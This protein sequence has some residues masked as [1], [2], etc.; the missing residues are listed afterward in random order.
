MQ[1]GK[2]IVGI[3]LCTDGWKRRCAGGGTPLINLMVL[4]R[5]H[6]AI[7]IKVRLP[8]KRGIHLSSSI[9]FCEAQ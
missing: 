4:T 3:M 5:D 1:N 2:V 7:F 6:G 9:A 8:E